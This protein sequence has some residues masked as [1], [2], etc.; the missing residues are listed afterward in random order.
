MKG[1]RWLVLIGSLLLLFGAIL[2]L[3]GY[4]FI[5]PRVAATNASPE[6]LNVF[7]ALWWSLSVPGIVLCPVIIWASRMPGGRGLVLLCTVIPA[8][9]GILLFCYLGWFIGSIIFS[10]V[11][12][13]LLVGGLMLPSGAEPQ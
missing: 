2:H 13:L 10:V 5:M 4:A 7:K 3:Y 1:A 11:T 6:I 8:A 9:T 12:V